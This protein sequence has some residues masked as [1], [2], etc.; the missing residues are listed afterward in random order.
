VRNRSKSSLAVI[1]FMR[2]SGKVAPFEV[3]VEYQSVYRKD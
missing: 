1:S 2:H 3:A